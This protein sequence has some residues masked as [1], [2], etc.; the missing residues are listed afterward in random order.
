MKLWRKAKRWSGA[1]LDTAFPPS[2]ASCGGSVGNAPLPHV[3]ERCFKRIRI[4]E[5]PRCLT[6]GY[7]F[8]GD[9]DSHEDCQHCERLTPQF[10]R[11][12]AVA[13]FRGPVRDLLY[14][15]KY[16]NGLW[17][18]E[19]IG[20]IAEYAEGLSDFLEEA[21]LVP[22]PL[23]PRKLRERGYNQSEL[24]AGSIAR[25]FDRPEVARLLARRVDTPS[26]TQFNRVERYRNLKNA[27]RVNRRVEI[28][29]KRHYVIVD[30]V[31]TTG[32]TLNACAAALQKAGA[33]N[34]DALTIGHG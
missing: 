18:A 12:W 14:A 5:D 27:F 17:A 25:R 1:L 3:C 26:Q 16:S 8:F 21:T 31:F 11:G 10:G 15:L 28:D 6:C 33:M 7:P 9:A 23:H 24:I 22:V 29:P 30:D 19:D 2:C 13:L 34:V 32:S 20:R 4:I